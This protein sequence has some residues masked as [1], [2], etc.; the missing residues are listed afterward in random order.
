MAVK[1]NI[2]AIIVGMLAVIIKVFE[3][4]NNAVIIVEA[5]RTPVIIIVYIY[6]LKLTFEIN[7]IAVYYIILIAIIIV[8]KREWNKNI[9]PCKTF[10]SFS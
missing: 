9:K 5:V 7:V 3:I 10:K 2:T 4:I 6:V 1:L 8:I